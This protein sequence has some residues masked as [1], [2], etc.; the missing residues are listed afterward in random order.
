MAR[1]GPAA[2]SCPAQARLARGPAGTCS[3]YERVPHRLGASQK[4]YMVTKLATVLFMSILHGSNRAEASAP[5]ECQVRVLVGV[6]DDLG[7]AWKTDS[8]LPVDIE[9]EGPNGGAFCAHGGSCLPRLAAAGPALTLLN[10]KV[11]PALG[12]GDFRLVPDSERGGSAAAAKLQRLQETTA[13]LMDLGFSSASS[14]TLADKFVNHRRSSDSQLVARALAGSRPALA[15][16]K[17]NNP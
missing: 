17:R 12:D 8:V 16:L 1:Q 9:R 15:T 2:E 5:Q 13:K 11:G 14:S 4:A 3:V 10:C 6:T 7:N